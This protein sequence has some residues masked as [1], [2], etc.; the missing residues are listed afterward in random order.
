MPR[1]ELQQRFGSPDAPATPWARA[2]EQLERAEIFWVSSVRPD[3]R[4]HVTPLLA[5]WLDDALHFCTGADERKARNIETNPHVVLTTGINELDRG[6]DVVVEGEAV[7][8][9]DEQ[10]LG[11]LATAFENKYGADW[12]YDVR[13]AAFAGPEGNLALVFRVAPVR[14]F[15]FSRGEFSQTRWVF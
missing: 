3:G 5:V 7:R 15:G 14:A 4:P 13:D 12:H 6:L 10:A 9:T 2:C 11:R 8:L 1:E